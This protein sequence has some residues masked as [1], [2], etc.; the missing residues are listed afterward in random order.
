MAESSNSSNDDGATHS[1]ESSL[2]ANLKVDVKVG[3]LHTVAENIYATPA[4][5]IREAV[6]NSIDNEAT[7]VVLVADPPTKT[8]CIYDNGIGITSSR[9]HEILENIGYGLFPPEPV[10][11]MSYFGLGL[12][13]IF[14]LGKNIKLF[15]RPHGGDCLLLLTVNTKEIFNPDNRNKCISE[16]K[17]MRLDSPAPLLNDFLDISF[18]GEPSSFTEI[19]IEDL[20]DEDFEAIC[21]QDFVTELSK[22]LPLRVEADE[23]FL[24]RFTG[25]KRSEIKDLLNDKIFCP[26]I[27]VY[28]G[29]RGEGL[30]NGMEDTE[31]SKSEVLEADI[32]QIWKY[33]PKFRTDLDFPDSTVEINHDPNSA[34]AYYIVHSIAKDLHRSKDD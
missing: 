32:R 25:L 13:S 15:T 14:R 30:P 23:P 28:F 33:F 11:K 1:T 19:V 6:A 3:I 27:E 17:E 20:Y 18:G 34:F 7:W 29:V 21:K 24:H 8:L 2:S 12:I 26:T 5:K 22:K 31:I 9:F 4:G 10:P 16:L